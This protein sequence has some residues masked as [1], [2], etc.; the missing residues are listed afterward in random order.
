MYSL[1]I[2]CGP[3]YPNDPPKIRFIHKVAIPCVDASGN[4]NFN[5]M[6]AFEWHRDSYLFQA[7]LAIR[8]QMKPNPVAQACAKIP[9]GTTY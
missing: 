3:G 5:R 4:V 7:V 9:D 6:S 1:K 2:E 8:N